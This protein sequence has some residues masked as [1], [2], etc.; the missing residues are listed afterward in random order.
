MKKNVLKKLICTAL[1]A[2]CVITSVV[3]TF[4]E[5]T[6]TTTEAATVKNI[7]SV[8]KYHLDGY[9][10]KLNI[11]FEYDEKGHYADV[12]NNILKERDIER[13][14]YIIKKLNCEF[15]RYNEKKKL[16]YKVN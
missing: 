13:Q 16:L 11:A 7:T 5:D 3:P 12:N 10:K 14:K 8:Y 2:V 9:D 15:W 1:T 6:V 4:A